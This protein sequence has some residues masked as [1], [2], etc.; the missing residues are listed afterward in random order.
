MK[1]IR[2]AFGS[3]LCLA[4]SAILWTACGVAPKSTSLEVTVQREVVR[5]QAAPPIAASTAAA[6]PSAE[7]VSVEE[8]SIRRQAAE[9]LIIKNGQMILEVQTTDAAINAAVDLTVALGGYI[10]GQEQHIDGQGNRFATLQVAVPVAQFEAA[11]RALRDLGTILSES[12]S[13]E[14]VT[15]EYVDLNARLENLRVTQTRLRS[16][17][18][19]ATTVEEALNVNAELSKIEEELNVIQ[20]RMNYLGDRAA[21]STISLEIRPI[22][23]TS[24]PT[25]PPTPTPLPTPQIWRPGDTA[26]TAIVNLQDTAQSMADGAIYFLIFCGPWLLPAVLI[27]Y[28]VWRVRRKRARQSGRAAV[29]GSAETPPAAS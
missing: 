2:Y 7:S 6:A 10:I 14:D 26:R 4:L 16:F 8:R 17:L 27:A 24:T 23:P 28:G 15:D 21:F 22:L 18:D 12:A 13:G 11:L 19:Q 1:P 29:V 20:G 25:P 5:E 3:V 9:R